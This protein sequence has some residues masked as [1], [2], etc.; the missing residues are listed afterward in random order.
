MERAAFEEDLIASTNENLYQNPLSC[1]AAKV[2][3]V[4]A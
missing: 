2:F 4:D 3:A 1:K